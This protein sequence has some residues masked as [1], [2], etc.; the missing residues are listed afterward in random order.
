MYMR[1]FISL[2][3]LLPLLFFA[4]PLEREKKNFTDENGMKQGKWV[5]TFENSKAVRYRGQF[6]DNRPI[7]EFEYFYNTG[8]ISAVMRFKDQN[9]AKSKMYH[10]NGNLLSVGNYFDQKKDSI[11]WYFNERKEV[12]NMETYNKGVLDG[13]QIVYYPADPSKVKVK[14]LEKCIFKEGQK[15]GPWEQYYESG[16][17]KAKGVYLNGSMNGIAYYYY[18]N[19]KVELNGEYKNG[20][21]NGC[22]LYFGK[23]D[24]LLDRS[25]YKNNI[26]LEGEEIEEFIKSRKSEQN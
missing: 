3:Y 7:G 22:W 11:W 13:E 14:V 9:N 16:R 8:E 1:L 19:G 15:N 18:S 5:V 21:K 6:K 26:K 23:D 12:L 17:M 20:F 25:Y 24:E 10:K 2:F 4:Q